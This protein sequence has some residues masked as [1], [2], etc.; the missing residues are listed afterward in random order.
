MAKGNAGMSFPLLHAIRSCVQP[1]AAFQ[2]H[3]TCQGNQ[4]TFILVAFID[5]ALIA[6]RELLDKLE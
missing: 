4:S 3:E 6:I 1:L 5:A 2:A